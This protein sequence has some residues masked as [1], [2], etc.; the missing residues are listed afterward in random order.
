MIRDNLLMWIGMELWH[1]PEWRSRK[2]IAQAIGCS[3][4]P[5]II[6]ALDEAVKSNILEQRMF[7]TDNARPV[8]K[9]RIADEYRERQ[10][11]E[12]KNHGR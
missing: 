11:E 10:I 8:I 7:R 3:K 5:S 2:E 1:L 6:W 4:S 12:A 9:Y